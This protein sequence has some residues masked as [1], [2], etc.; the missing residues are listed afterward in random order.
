MVECLL[1]N[2]L[3][4]TDVIFNRNQSILIALE[5][6]FILNQREKPIIDDDDVNSSSSRIR[7]IG[8]WLD[9][10]RV[11]SYSFSPERTKGDFLFAQLA[12]QN[13]EA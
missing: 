11:S 2:E 13:K 4:K 6:K 10:T 7:E 5:T 9:P 1:E 8:E 12:E 3:I